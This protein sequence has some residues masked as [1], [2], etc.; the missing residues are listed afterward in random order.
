MGCHRVKNPAIQLFRQSVL[1]VV[2]SGVL[3]VLSPRTLGQHFAEGHSAGFR[4]GHAGGFSGGGFH[5]G[6]SAPHSFDGFTA[7][8]V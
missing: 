3:L 5:G 1:P 4:G 8:R 6:F 7:P 2:M